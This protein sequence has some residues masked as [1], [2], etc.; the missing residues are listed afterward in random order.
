MKLLENCVLNTKY[1]SQTEEKNSLQG[2]VKKSSLL[3]HSDEEQRFMR[4]CHPQSSHKLPFDQGV[5]IHI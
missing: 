4:Q 5:Q 3:S 2:V 1:H